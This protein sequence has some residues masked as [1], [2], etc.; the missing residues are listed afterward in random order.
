MELT[1]KQYWEDYY[2]ASSEDRDTIIKICGKYDEF[3]DLLIKSCASP[4]KSILEI[5]AF[6]G[7]Y[8]AYVA[9]KYQLE[10]TGLDFNPDESKFKRNMEVMGV[11][12]YQYICADFLSYEPSQR[13]DV[14]ISNG[15]I[16]HFSNYNDVLDKHVKF[17]NNG[18][19][20]LIMIPNKRYL[21]AVYGNLLDRQ[22]QLAHNLSCMK[23]S[24]F[25]QFALR[26]NLSIQFLNFQGGFPYKVHTSLK[27]WQKLIYH[28]VRFFSIKLSKL[29][30]RNVSKFW[31]GTIVGVFKA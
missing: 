19:A 11:K 23:L 12:S 15:F 27:F 18:G 21:R 14:V 9:S 30:S 8:L 6:P 10:P 28:P 5:G 13:Y 3:W 31:S 24:V 20:M 22:N 1:S 7:R 29:L 2:R 4:P 26:N 16:E 17:L 25:K